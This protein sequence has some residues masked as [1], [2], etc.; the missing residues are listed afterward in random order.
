MLIKLLAEDGTLIGSFHKDR[1]MFEDEA[2]FYGVV[3]HLKYEGM[4]VPVQFQEKFH[5]TKW[6]KYPKENADP[7]EVE[8]FKEVF[9][10]YYFPYRLA[11]KGYKLEGVVYEHKRK[12]I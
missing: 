1:L 5:C 11:S 4:E 10:K 12:R 2:R 6:V 8:L 7:K 3:Q 9:L